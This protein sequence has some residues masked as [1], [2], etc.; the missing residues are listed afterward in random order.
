MLMWIAS[1]LMG[2]EPGSRHLRQRHRTM[3]LH[4]LA[5]MVK[6]LILLRAGD[7]AGLKRKQRPVFFK[8]GRDLRSSHLMRSILGAK[9]RRALHHRDPIARIAILIDALTNIDAWAARFAKRLR[10]GFMR[11][12]AIPPAP[13]PDSVL[14]GPPASPPACADSS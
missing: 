11:L 7:I 14:L 2:R 6:Q 8:H 1:L 9:L 12:W 4:G 13:T 10:C 5:T 3:S